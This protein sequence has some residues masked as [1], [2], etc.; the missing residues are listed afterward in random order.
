LDNK[1]VGGGLGWLGLDSTD[2]SSID[3]SDSDVT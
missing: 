3:N 1:S 2:T